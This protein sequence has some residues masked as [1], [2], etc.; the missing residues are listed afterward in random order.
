MY[1]LSEKWRKH[2]NIIIKFKRK[3]ER[4]K[5]SQRSNEIRMIEILFKITFQMTKQ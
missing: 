3:I 5:K 2:K 4:E 1:I